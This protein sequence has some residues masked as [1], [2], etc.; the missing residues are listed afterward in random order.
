MTEIAAKQ[1]SVDT[2]GAY[3]TELYDEDGAAILFPR[4]MIGEKLRGGSH[5]CYPY[6]GPDTAG[7]MPQHGFGRVVPWHSDVSPDKRA[8]TCTYHSDDE[9]F[10]GLIAVLRYQLHETGS[11]FTT[12]LTVTNTSDQPRVVMPGFHPYFSIDSDDTML[13]GQKIVTT[14]FEPFQSFPDR[15]RM[16]LQTPERTVTITSDTLTHMVVWTDAKGEYLCI[17]PTLQ[18]NG[19]DSTQAGK[20]ILAAGQTV[21]HQYA[22]TWE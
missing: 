22:I 15:T 19:F 9:V 20:H 14:D 13:N 21:V 3:V 12:T 1:F 4:T 17:E 10:S 6:F 7:I 5:V 18:G 8:V 16:T 2:I 11:S